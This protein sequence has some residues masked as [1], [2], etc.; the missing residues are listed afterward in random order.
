MITKKIKLILKSHEF[1]GLRIEL[2]RLRDI[3]WKII[4][5]YL[6]GR[7]QD[8]KIILV[9]KRYL[10][11]ICLCTMI[12][13]RFFTWVEKGKCT[14]WHMKIER[15]FMIID[16]KEFVMTLVFQK[17]RNSLSSSWN[18]KN[19]IENTLSWPTVKSASSTF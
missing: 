19:I 13:A 7:G 17:E 5:S 12:W 15:W 9:L 16:N 14:I 2:Y 1:I 18:N 6:K 4:F 11:E 3:K 10:V 8:N